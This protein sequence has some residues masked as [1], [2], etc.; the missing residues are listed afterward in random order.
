VVA[1]W[2][3]ADVVADD[4]DEPQPA[5]TMAAD[6]SPASVTSVGRILMWTPLDGRCHVQAL[7][8][9]EGPVGAEVWPIPGAGHRVVARL[10]P[11]LCIDQCGAVLEQ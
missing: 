7:T 6:D 1:V 10:G 8:V 3:P 4:P 9:A 5:I 2:A 11:P